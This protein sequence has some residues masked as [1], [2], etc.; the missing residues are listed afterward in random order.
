MDSRFSLCQNETPTSADVQVSLTADRDGNRPPQLRPDSSP[1]PIGAR[2]CQRE[3]TS[4]LAVRPARMSLKA[5][6]LGRVSGV[7][8]AT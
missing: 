4:G 2:S 1:T 5:R 8:A 6:A 3:E 7:A